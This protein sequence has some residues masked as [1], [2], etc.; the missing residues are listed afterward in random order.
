MKKIISF[1]LACVMMFGLFGC[2]SIP[3][4]ETSVDIYLSDL[5]NFFIFEEA[6]ELGLVGEDKIEFDWNNYIKEDY[7]Y[8]ILSS[9]ITKENQATVEVKIIN[10]DLGLAFTKTTGEF[11]LYAFGA[12]F[13]ENPPSDEE[14]QK[15]YIETLKNNKNSSNFIET[16]YAF[17]LILVDNN[18][19]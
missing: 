13:S 6:Q 10:K 2:S 3:S 5:S 14:L 12:A 19:N 1:F 11:I 9:S 18:W 4:P 15:L 7:T 17:E 16:N 8:E